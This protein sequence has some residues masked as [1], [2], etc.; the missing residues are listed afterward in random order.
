MRGITGA[1]TGHFHYKPPAMTHKQPLKLNEKEIYRNL[2]HWYTHATDEQ[3]EEGKA[4]YDAAF[5]TVAGIAHTA[6]VTL[7]AAAAVTAVLSPRI[8][9]SRNVTIAQSVCLFPIDDRQD[10]FAINLEKARRIL[11]GERDVLAGNKVK[12]FYANLLGDTDAVTVDGWIW[13]AAVR[14]SSANH[15]ITDNQYA[16]VASVV[17]ELARD[18]QTTPAAMQAII[19]CSIRGGDK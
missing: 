6:G 17:R 13:K 15:R 18:F 2:L 4:W 5:I 7:E 1:E 19:W 8:T 16:I 9:W 10:V 11:A 12:N 14:G 3:R